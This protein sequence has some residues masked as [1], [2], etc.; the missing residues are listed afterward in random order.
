MT[1]ERSARS[2]GLVPAGTRD[3][4][5]RSA[6]LA[7][8]GLEALE[9]QKG[10]IL[11]FPPDRSLGTLYARG[12]QDAAADWRKIG[13][14][15]GPV[16]V[17]AGQELLLI[18]GGEGEVEDG[19]DI[20]PLAALGLGDLRDLTL[21][22]VAGDLAS[23]TGLVGEP[24]GKPSQLTIWAPQI[25]GGGMAQLRALSQLRGL[26]LE[27]A[28]ECLMLYR[29]YA[30]LVLWVPHFQDGDLAGCRALRGVETLNLWGTQVDDEGLAHLHE[31]PGLASLRLIGSQFGNAG[32]AHL[33]GLGGLRNLV[34]WN[35]SA[36]RA[37]VQALAVALPQ[38]EISG[39]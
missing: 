29:G 39:A 20:S 6:S 32:L 23:A 31:L 26:Q 37:A 25:G 14:A 18:V 24:G 7:R 12:L 22:V 27:E 8:R 5:T 34:L 35:T 9:A 1:D 15:Q 13:R 38:C 2:Q 17:P 11:R 33:R 19:Y 4:V 21:W 3:V 36:T 28:R 30:E 16:P 10:R